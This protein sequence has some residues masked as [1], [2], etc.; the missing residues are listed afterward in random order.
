[1][2]IDDTISLQSPE[3]ASS[4]QIQIGLSDT[5]T[6]NGNMSVTKARKKTFEY[7]PRSKRSVEHVYLPIEEDG[8]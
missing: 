4:S 1:M 8:V 2:F 5:T 6:R 7:P 3:E